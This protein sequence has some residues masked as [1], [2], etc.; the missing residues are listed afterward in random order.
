ME[1]KPARRRGKTSDWWDEQTALEP[2]GNDRSKNYVIRRLLRDDKALAQQVINGEITAHEAAKRAGIRK[3]TTQVRTDDVLQA[4]T[5][6]LR[7]FSDEDIRAALDYL[8]P[9]AV[10]E[11]ELEREAAQKK[12]EEARR[13]ALRRRG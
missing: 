9:E 4:V 13:S 1:M 10:A 8:L 3:P 2:L 6:L 11:R 5:T 12:L 7:H